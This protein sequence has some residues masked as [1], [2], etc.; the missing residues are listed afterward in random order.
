[1]RK[2]NPKIIQKYHLHKL[3][4]PINEE[5]NKKEITENQTRLKV[6]DL[7]EKYTMH[8]RGETSNT[9]GKSN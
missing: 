2:C 5:D 4:I 7:S 8:Y 6:I 3:R 1:M 9:L